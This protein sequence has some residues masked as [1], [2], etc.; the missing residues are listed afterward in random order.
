MKVERLQEQRRQ[1]QA[2][3]IGGCG[4]DVVGV[5][6]LLRKVDAAEV[7]TYH[8]IRAY[9][10]EHGPIEL[11]APGTRIDRRGSLRRLMACMK[12]NMVDSGAWASIERKDRAKAGIGALTSRPG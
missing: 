3:A 11:A 9:E 8:R 6:R 7:A 5:T 12:R 4:T 2:A 10:L 1:V